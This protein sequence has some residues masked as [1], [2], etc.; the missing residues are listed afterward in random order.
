M[1]L[2][3]CTLTGVDDATDL[4]TIAALSRD[5]P[6]VEWGC[7]YS[8]KRQGT[9]GRYPAVPTLQRI[10]R[11]L[12]P[13]VRVALHVCGRGVPDL[14]TGEP[15][16]LDLVRRLVARQGRLQLNF[17]L[18]R[19]PV[20]FIG[21]RRL[22]DRFPTL[23]VI[24]Q[25]NT[26]NATVWEQLREY[27]NHAVLFDASGGNGILPGAWPPPLPELACGYAGGL[28]P[29]TLYEHLGKISDAAGDRPTWIDM[30]GALRVEDSAGVD[31]FNLDRCRFCLEVV[32]LRMGSRPDGVETPPSVVREIA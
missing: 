28:G 1:N 20:D 18:A 4:S 12:P 6:V 25:H 30:E 14:L 2:T 3:H 10:L 5:Y 16:V 17:N 23:I 24:T 19:T 11:E 32:A 13:E 22:L 7:L 9:P 15:V 21:L 8:P 27:P 31:R 29:A 26:A